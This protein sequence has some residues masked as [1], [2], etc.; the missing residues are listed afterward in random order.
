M[1]NSNYKQVVSKCRTYAP[2]ANLN[3][4]FYEPFIRAT[5]INT[6][7]VKIQRISIAGVEMPLKANGEVVL[8]CQ[9]NGRN[10]SPIEIVEIT[11]SLPIVITWTQYADAT[12]IRL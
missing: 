11:G 10:I 2:G 9:E 12:W 3:K 4:S 7:P 6:D 5:I 8:D 1:A